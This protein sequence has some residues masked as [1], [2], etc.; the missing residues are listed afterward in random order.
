MNKK[1]LLTVA[2]VIYVI[3][4][5]QS[6]VITAD[7]TGTAPANSIGSG[8]W[9][10]VCKLA[11]RVWETAL[12]GPGTLTVHFV[13]DKDEPR[14]HHYL[15]NQGGD[16]NREIEAT[17]VFNGNPWFK[18][19]I[20]AD[21][22]GTASFNQPSINLGGGLVNA[23]RYR[24]SIVAEMSMDLF[25][26]ALHEI[27]HALGLSGDNTSFMSI[28]SSGSITICT[29]LPY[30]G[31]VVPLASNADGFTSHIADITTG[32]LMSG[33]IGW[34]QRALPSTLDIITVAQLSGYTEVNPDLAPVL[35]IGW[36]QS[37]AG[38]PMPPIFELSWVQPLA[39]P[40]GTQYRV[41]VCTD[42][43][44]GNWVT[45]EGD[46]VVSN[47]VYRQLVSKTSDS[48]FFRLKA[49]PVTP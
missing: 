31:T 25:T 9:T 39:P 20:D 10:N 41:Q 36:P 48:A 16:P 34:C 24:D 27:G 35:S 29:N 13:W 45:A 17:I 46:A 26:S 15:D 47:G 38:R 23:A 14:A 40:P 42:L 43:A 11:C 12:L 49:E 8:N 21:P 6:M 18:W 7:F 1:L 22:L 44:T 32:N 28:C 33:L 2:L 30:H 4:S 37:V 5:A 19:F 3:S